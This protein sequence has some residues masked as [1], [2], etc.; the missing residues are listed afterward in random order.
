MSA[1]LLGVTSSARAQRASDSA[2][3]SELAPPPRASAADGERAAFLDTDTHRLDERAAPTADHA[4]ARAADARRRLLSYLEG[5]EWWRQN[6][7]HPDAQRRARQLA[8]TA[9]I[10]DAVRHHRAA[11]ALRQRAVRSR[12]PAMLEE[13]NREYALAIEAYRAHLE[14]HRN[15]PIAYELQ[16]DLADALYWSER[17]EEAADA[18]AAVR[19]SN[20]DDAYLS[21]SA[22][23]VVES[24]HRLVERAETR[25]EIVVRRSAEDVPRPEGA[26]RRVRPVEVPAPLQRLANAREVYLARVSDAQ[27]REHVRPAYAYNDALL[28]YHY[29]YWPQARERFLR[30]YEASCAGPRSSEAGF[31]AW[32][33]LY[34]MAAAMEDADEVERLSLDL[35][36]RRCTFGSELTEEA[37]ERFCSLAENRETAACRA[38]SAPHLGYVLVRYARAM[39]LYR[40]AEAASGEA[41]RHLFERAATE[42]VRAVDE[43]PDD[44]EAPLALLQAAYA[45]ERVRRFDSASQID[46]RVIAMVTP[47]L[48]A[49]DG[50]RRT[51][52][53]A[54]LATATFRSAFTHHRFFELDRAVEDYRR[55]SDSAVF[56]R[57]VD[58]EMP[59]RIT[60]ALINTARILEQ[61]QRY[62]EAATYYARAAERLSDPVERETARYRVAEMAFRAGDWTGARLAMV[63]FVDRYRND[64]GAVELVVQANARIVQTYV[65]QRARASSVR[66]AREAVV[67]AFERLGGAPGGSAAE[68]AAQSRFLLAD[69]PLA[70]LES[71][72]IDPGRRATTD[73]FVAELTR[74]VEESARRVQIVARG[75]EPIL[76]YRSPTW[77][78]AAL[79]RQARAYELLARAVLDARITMPA[80]LQRRTQRASA[81][82]RDEVRV[83]FEDRVHEVLDAQARPLECV[84]IV[85]YALAAR[86]AQRADLD[87]DRSREATDRLQAYGDERI[88]EC[89]AQ[90]RAHDPTLEP[91]RPGELIRAL[92]GRHEPMPSG[93]APPPLVADQR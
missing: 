14:R 82:A 51:E 74:Q 89:V 64:R 73:T 81:A 75:Y 88:A 43:A 8:E 56:A 80:D 23:R 22:R 77:T 53:E 79:T 15:E 21:E 65:E 67:S 2:S 11:R 68:H 12:D 9:W 49:A 84:A 39:E 30:I 58:P 44:S 61:Q 85:R 35:D 71:L 63:D 18:Y 47:M 93:L 54:I 27:D 70:D 55:L 90:R 59:E 3:L 26:P 91:Y 78:I 62:D 40:R 17:Y 20:I 4:E 37:R 69:E 87:D 1:A 31:D 19:D 6:M 48:S 76:A 7:D 36:R 10:A 86:A 41:E 32:R 38:S 66:D 45:L 34:D 13:A 60:D 92:R 28:L 33:V 52:L 50:E 25:G 57:S 46:A 29:G 72:R 83:A 5:S 16:Y 42:L 24:L